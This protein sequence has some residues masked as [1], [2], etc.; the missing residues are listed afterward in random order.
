V[1]EYRDAEG[2]PE[3]LPALAAEL[4]R[5]KVDNL[6]SWEAIRWA[7]ARGAREFDF[8]RSPCDNGTHRCKLGWGAAGVGA[9]VDTAPLRR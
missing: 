5:L 9:R 7:I 1:I 4:V 2:K 3:R 6:I 8:G